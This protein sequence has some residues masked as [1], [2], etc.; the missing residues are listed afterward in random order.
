MER[1]TV[2]TK[3]PSVTPL[4]DRPAQEMTGLGKL[5]FQ[6]TTASGAIPLEGAEVI[7]R[8]YEFTGRIF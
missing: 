7:L 1:N 2:N 3:N 5:V 4:S 6:I 8:K